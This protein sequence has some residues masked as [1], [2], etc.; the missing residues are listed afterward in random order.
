MR[1]LKRI[2]VCNAVSRRPRYKLCKLD[3][4]GTAL[5]V[6]AGTGS[7]VDA[8]VLAYANGRV[9]EASAF[10]HADA[11]TVAKGLIYTYESLDDAIE[12]AGKIGTSEAR[13]ND[14]R[15][16]FKVTPIGFKRANKKIEGVTLC[17]AVLVGNEVWRS[18]PEPVWEDV[19]DDCDIDIYLDD[20]VIVE[21]G[22][23]IDGFK[24]EGDLAIG[25]K[26]FKRDC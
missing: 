26:V 3:E 2:E 5:S 22:M 11:D 12:A 18:E 1:P 16:I 13:A 21:C 6:I 24:V 20:E 10:G 19:T 25:F 4:N 14:T 7:Y 17:E 15:V 9:T 8:P 23:A